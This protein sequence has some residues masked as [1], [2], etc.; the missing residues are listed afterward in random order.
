M[1]RLVIVGLR[2]MKGPSQRRQTVVLFLC[3]H[4]AER[5]VAGPE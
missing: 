3:V 2:G 1:T 5:C 4:N